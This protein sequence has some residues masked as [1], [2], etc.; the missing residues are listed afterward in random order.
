MV[1]VF[2]LKNKLNIFFT[3]QGK[4]QLAELFNDEKELAKMAYLVDIFSLLNTLNLS[5]Q[6]VNAT[7]LEF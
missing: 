6:D 7:V 2:E 5:L 3:N 1:R 4:I